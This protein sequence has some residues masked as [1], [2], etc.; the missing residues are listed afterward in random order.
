MQLT[1]GFRAQFPGA[2]AMLHGL[3]IYRDRDWVGV[4][5]EAEDWQG[6]GQGQSRGPL[7]SSM[8][9][10]IDRKMQHAA[11]RHQRAIR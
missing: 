2:V 7:T 4:R 8:I 11:L 3:P 6:F 1:S 10:Q 9:R 5:V